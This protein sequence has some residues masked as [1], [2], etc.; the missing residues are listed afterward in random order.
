MMSRRYTRVS[1]SSNTPLVRR[2]AALQR[3]R[4]KPSGE[5][6][7]VSLKLLLVRRDNF[8]RLFHIGDG[9]QEMLAIFGRT[10]EVGG[11]VAL[12]NSDLD[13]LVLERRLNCVKESLVQFVGFK[14]INRVHQ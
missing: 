9:A 3:F 5:T 4:R 12:G 2:G 14:L 6:R 10:Q 1:N 8:L 7:R 13:F 11:F